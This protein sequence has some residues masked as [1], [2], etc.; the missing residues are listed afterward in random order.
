MSIKLFQ[1]LG[2]T[3]DH[4]FS[5]GGS[6]AFIG[7]SDSGLN[8]DINV[9]VNP[10]QNPPPASSNSPV[11]FRGAASIPPNGPVT[12]A[13]ISTWLP[14]LPSSGPVAAVPDVIP[15][16]F[17]KESSQAPFETLFNDFNLKVTPVYNFWTD[18]ELTNDHDELGDRD[19]DSVPRYVK[20]SW[21]PAPDLFP[22]LDPGATRMRPAAPNPSQNVTSNINGVT[23]SPD[24][25]QP[26]NFPL[27]MSSLANGYTNP[28]VI[29]S[30]IE[31]PL[32]AS[33]L[34]TYQSLSEVD[35][36]QRLDEVAFLRN[37]DN[38]GTTLSEVI[39][40][41]HQLTNGVLG[42]TDIGSSKL[43]AK[44]E[45]LRSDTFDQ[46]F[47]VHKSP[48]TGGELQ[49]HGQV[50]DS[51]SLSMVVNSVTNKSH[52]PIPFI[53]L[54]Q[55]LVQPA[56]STSMKHSAQIKA[57][58]VD[59]SIGGA[60]SETRVSTMTQPHHVESMVAI[61][62]MLPNLEMLNA[63]SL[64]EIL[65]KSIV[66]M[67]STPSGV[68]DLSYV[69]YVI[70]KYSLSDAGNFELVD[71]I[72]VPDRKTF[73]FIDTQV[74][75]GGVYRYRI[76]SIV[77]WTHLPNVSVDGVDP[78]NSSSPSSQT[79][80]TA[81]SKSSY[82]GSAWNLS[83]EYG[84]IIDIQPPAPPDEFSIRTDSKKKK[85][86]VTLKLPDNPQRDIYTIG[87]LR[88]VQDSSG[89]DL[90]LWTAIGPKFSAQNVFFEDT[91]VEFFEDSRLR[92]VYSA[93]CVSRHN[94][95]S[96]LCEQ[97]AARLNKNSKV[98]GE[99]P[100]EFISCKGVD[101]VAFGSFS[102]YPFKKTMVEVIMIP[103][104]SKD[105]MTRSMAKG[106]FVGREGKGS[107][108]INSK[109]HVI[110]IQSLDTGETI[111]LNL[112]VDYEDQQGVVNTIESGIYIPPH[113][114]GND[115]G[116]FDPFHS[117]PLIGQ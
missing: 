15:E 18:D 12:Q 100:V 74:K 20:I 39:S 51:P 99:Y 82:F 43:P 109:Q 36:I 114:F 13:P 4:P 80:M 21:D 64:N 61:A 76:R 88:K 79:S 106:V 71:T 10:S 52:Q 83:W 26:E 81:P 111:D 68:A 98:Y 54:A 47:S 108:P 85:V 14:S 115:P 45:Q 117:L 86:I 110:R 91:A 59:L 56:P 95:V 1:G 112:E 30:I 69:G 53:S 28:G 116:L 72:G 6:S 19:P 96:P 63:S 5:I 24:H 75:Y 84:Q 89:N 77:R 42:A 105:L 57:T 97:L 27:V 101:V 33:G 90:T 11:P 66:P 32:H 93:Y 8:V 73:E 58:F 22:V 29:N 46:R 107:S 92:Y 34:D 87:I 37:H 104:P 23:F 49:I 55:N 67:F 60:I 94:E 62:G 7:S 48:F 31:M 102:V 38:Q 50:P 44:D 41:V 9:L 16:I 17:S 65:R 3:N 113:S 78:T 25:M 40:N 2:T 70:E 35:P 103:P